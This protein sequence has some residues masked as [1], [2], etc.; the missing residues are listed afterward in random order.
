MAP[1]WSDYN[2]HSRSQDSSFDASHWRNDDQDQSR[3]PPNRIQGMQRLGFIEQSLTIPGTAQ[4]D[5][6]RLGDRRRAHV[7][8]PSVDV[9]PTQQPQE[10]IMIDGQDI[11]QIGAQMRQ[12]NEFFRLGASADLSRVLDPPLQPSQ[13]QSR[14]HT[15]HL[16]YEPTSQATD[17]G[18]A[19]EPY[20]PRWDITVAPTDPWTGRIPIPELSPDVSV[21]LLELAQSE[22]LL[23]DNDLRSYPQHQTHE[24][25]SP[26]IPQAQHP[27]QSFE[28]T[29]PAFFDDGF[30]RGIDR[31][32]F[33]SCFSEQRII[34]MQTQLH[35]SIPY[36]EVFADQN[37][38]RWAMLAHALGYASPPRQAIGNFEGSNA[39][40]WLPCQADYS[41]WNARDA[42]VLQATCLENEIGVYW[43]LLDHFGTQAQ[44]VLG[45]SSQGASFGIQQIRD[46]SLQA[47]QSP[48]LNQHP[49]ELEDRSYQ[50]HPA[51]G[52]QELL[53]LQ[54]DYRIEPADAPA[55][56]GR[57]LDFLDES[58][59]LESGA[60]EELLSQNSPLDHG[61]SASIP[62][63]S[64]PSA[65]DASLQQMETA[66]SLPL[67]AQ[68][69]SVVQ[70]DGEAVADPQPSGNTATAAAQSIQTQQ[71]QQAL[72]AQNSQAAK[73]SR[74]KDLKRLVYDPNAMLHPRSAT[75]AVIRLATE[76]DRAAYTADIS[77]Y[78]PKN[79]EEARKVPETD[80]E[81][82]PYVLY[83]LESMMDT[84]QAEDKKDIKSSFHKRW[85]AEALKTKW[86]VSL[87]AMETICWIIA[88]MARQYH[89]DGPAFLNLFDRLHQEKAEK[90]QDL[91]FVERIKVICTVLLIS[92]SRVDTCLKYE[93]LGSLVAFPLS[94]LANCIAN[95]P[96]NEKRKKKL[97]AGNKALERKAEKKAKKAA[98]KKAAKGTVTADDRDALADANGTT[99]QDRAEQEVEEGDKEIEGEE[100]EEEDDEDDTDED[101]D[102]DD[103]DD[104]QDGDGSNDENGD[105]GADI[106]TGLSQPDANP[107]DETDRDNGGH[108]GRANDPDTGTGASKPPPGNSHV[109]RNH[110]ERAS[111]ASPMT[112]LDTQE[113]SELPTKALTAQSAGAVLQPQPPTPHAKAAALQPGRAATSN[114]S[115]KRS[116]ADALE[117]ANSSKPPM[118]NDKVRHGPIGVFPAANT[119]TQNGMQVSFHSMGHLASITA[120]DNDPMPP[121]EPV[122]GAARM[123]EYMQLAASK[124]SRKRSATAE[125]LGLE[126]PSAPKRSRNASYTDSSDAAMFGTP[127]TI[128]PPTLTPPTKRRATEA[129]LGDINVREKSARSVDGQAIAPKRRRAP[130][131]SAE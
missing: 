110:T 117:P 64:Q 70:Q 17:E 68:E 79:P 65:H 97:A 99:L 115:R 90:N 41:H 36:H 103:D 22:G 92:K 104:D 74:K 21:R 67:P 23:Q 2:S 55:Q 128:R 28:N 51:E 9:Q 124:N 56:T 49:F 89:R 48:A 3:T 85:S 19:A 111:V 123:R 53:W 72:A 100:E 81:L 1:R 47:M 25:Q 54:D 42:E 61:S 84:S 12:P 33:L 30:G 39:P 108:S 27:T 106:S 57:P 118:S 73:P 95:R 7:P 120:Q 82:E 5:W 125:H 101:D 127:D 112:E 76:A 116:A 11:R 31:D 87:E 62:I 4:V 109:Y 38:L 93:N 130:P 60:L 66:R 83:M 129:G 8:Q 113:P 50:D 107:D 44:L 24:S 40:F 88:K 14:P 94:A 122:S 58:T 86:P 34:Y 114:G 52:I 6:Q 35:E 121:P 26:P 131:S 45:S 20:V 59:P 32:H 102:D 77:W 91:T 10:P 29:Q 78:K 80:V 71:L 105:N 37:P 119:L 126:L 43:G 15:E 16:D 96:F 75:D 63:S 98:A 18:S 13:Q 46:P 69:N